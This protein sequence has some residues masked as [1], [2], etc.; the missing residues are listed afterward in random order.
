MIDS[1]IHGIQ[2]FIPN[3]QNRQ[4]QR[5]MYERGWSRTRDPR[6]PHG[7]GSGEREGYLLGEDGGNV[8]T[9]PGVGHREVV[10][11]PPQRGIEAAGLR[12]E[13]AIKGGW[14]RTRRHAHQ[15]D[16]SDGKEASNHRSR[17]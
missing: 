5:Q 10:A 14:Y 17:R 2:Q 6:H 16:Q 8:L 4:I 11:A 13:R 15:S 1:T 3:K 12:R 9:E 7:C